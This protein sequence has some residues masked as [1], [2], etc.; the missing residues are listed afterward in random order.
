MKYGLVLL[1]VSSPKLRMVEKEKETKDKPKDEGE[2]TGNETKKT[3]PVKRKLLANFSIQE[4][5]TASSETTAGIAMKEKREER[6]NLHSP[7]PRRRK[8]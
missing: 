7:C 4:M 5:V 8:R 6:G 2:E 1:K 3:M